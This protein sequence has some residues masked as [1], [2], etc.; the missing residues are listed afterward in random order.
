MGGYTPARRWVV[1]LGDGR[2]AFV[3]IATDELT[4]SWIRDEHV[5]YSILRGA[6]FMPAYLGFYDDGRRPV[7]ALEDLSEATWPPPWDRKQVDAVLTCLG[8]VAATPPP[9]GLPRLDDD[10]LGLRRCWLQVERDPEPFLSLGLCSAAWLDEHLPT[11]RDSAATAPLAG[12]ALLHSDVRSDN[13]CFRRDG[14]AALVDWNWAS[15]GDPACDP[16]FWLASLRAEGG[17]EPEEVV[18]DA[19]PGLVSCLAGYMCFHAGLD[20]I[21]TA[22]DVR[23]VQRAQA[24][25]AL[26]WAARALGL[27]P[28]A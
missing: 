19:P 3:K 2:S 20:E 5:V 7:L 11:L 15:V 28:P 12:S 24:R 16:V 10:R 1:R 4:A 18:P 14:T 27:S 8:E 13:L 25:I 23:E 6:P 22:P 9:D 21:P 17:P 26:P